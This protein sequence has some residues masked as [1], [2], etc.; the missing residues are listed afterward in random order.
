MKRKRKSDDNEDTLPSKK[1]C[2]QMPRPWKIKLPEIKPPFKINNLDDLIHLAWYYK[3]DTFDWFK[4]WSL[5][6]ALTELNEMVGMN[7]LKQGVID[8]I[9]YHLQN[10]HISENDESDMLHTVLLGKPGCGKTTTAKILA[11][12]Y[13]KLGFLK[14]DKVIT[15]KRSDLIGKYVGHSESKTMDLLESSLG[16]VFF[17][18][19]AYSM[20][21]GDKTD[22]F[23]KASVDLINQ[24]LTEHKKEFVCII[25]G[26]EQEIYQNFFSIN[27]GLE[28]RFPWKFS[29][30]GY[31]SIEMLKIF[32]LK[33]S[34]DTWKLSDKGLKEVKRIFDLYIDKFPNYGG[35]IDNFFTFC[36][37]HHSRRVF[38]LDKSHRKTLTCT[39]IKNA[40]K[41]YL[42][43]QQ[44]GKDRFEDL[45][46]SVRKMWA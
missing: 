44:K 36:K 38:G 7:S 10:L 9:L 35:D 27:P 37:T 2:L 11:K 20:G 14:S 25:A 32:N 19:E 3:G 16:G 30:D 1:L 15:A 42:E 41:D 21:S 34:K 29:V 26:Y 5:I 40:Y 33:L 39:D 6:P 17:L 8:L 46:L 22:S 43:K 31:D 45:P 4:L 28:R 18:D 12:I 24:F 13:C 23:A